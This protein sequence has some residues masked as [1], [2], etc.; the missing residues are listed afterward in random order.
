MV[1]HTQQPRRRENGQGA[2]SYDTT[3][4]AGSGCSTLDADADGP[5]RRPPRCAGGNPHRG[6]A[7]KLDALRGQTSA[8]VRS[9]V[10]AR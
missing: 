6:P 9:C 5:P 2:I 1:Q 10:P 4:G 7:D 3:P 8:G